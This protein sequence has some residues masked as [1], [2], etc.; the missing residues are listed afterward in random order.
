M[1][2]I[3]GSLPAPV[4]GAYASLTPIT[5]EVVEA[6]RTAARAEAERTSLRVLAPQIG[7]GHST[8]HNFLS[9]ANPHPRVRRLLFDWY[10]GHQRTTASEF[11][12]LFEGLAE[13]VRERVRIATARELVRGYR[14]SGLIV[15]EWLGVA[16]DGGGGFDEP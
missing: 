16:C 1:S 3:V 9:G 8:L 12:R 15:P 5:P 6:I 7:I 10:T 14:D 2:I 11:D 13:D 4:R